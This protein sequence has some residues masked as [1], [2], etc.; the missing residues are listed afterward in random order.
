MGMGVHICVH[1]S[2]DVKDQLHVLIFKYG[3]LCFFDTNFLTDLYSKSQ[4][5]YGG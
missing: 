1:A 3:P 5:R 2:V 4:A